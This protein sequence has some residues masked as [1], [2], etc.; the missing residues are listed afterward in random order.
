[1]YVCVGPPLHS[2]WAL[3]GVYTS[4]YLKVVVIVLTRTT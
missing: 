2:N 3:F 4:K 1:M